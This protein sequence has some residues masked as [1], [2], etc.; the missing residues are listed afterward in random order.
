[1]NGVAGILA[2]A[3]EDRTL[4]RGQ[5]I[6]L[7]GARRAQPLGLRQGVVGERG[8]ATHVGQLVVALDDTDRGDEPRRVLQR[9][10]TPGT[11]PR[12]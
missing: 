7:E 1:M 5:D 6:A 4:H 10:R 8:R 9:A 3:A 11:P 12:P 2:A